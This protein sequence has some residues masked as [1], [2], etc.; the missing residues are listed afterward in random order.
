MG[1]KGLLTAVGANVF[2]MIAL[3]IGLVAFVAVV[4]W[5]YSRPREQIE[6]ESRLWLDDEN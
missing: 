3:V 6:A 5:A 4:I 1:L 2:G